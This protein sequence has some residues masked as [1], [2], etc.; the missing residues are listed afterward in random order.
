MKKQTREI[1]EK[2]QILCVILTNVFFCC[3]YL[4]FK[5]DFKYPRIHGGI[6]THMEITYFTNIEIRNKNKLVCENK[7]L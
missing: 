1:T 7:Q 4:Q 3:R 6:V 5:H 2:G